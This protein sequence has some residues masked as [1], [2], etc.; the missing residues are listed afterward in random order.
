MRSGPVTGRTLGGRLPHTPDARGRES[1][2]L[3]PMAATPLTADELRKLPK[4]QGASWPRGVILRCAGCGRTG[5]P[6][7]VLGHRGRTLRTTCRRRDPEAFLT[8]EDANERS[9]D[10]EAELERELDEQ[11]AAAT[12]AY[13]GLPEPDS[14]AERTKQREQARTERAR[15]IDERA[16]TREASGRERPQK[17]PV[18]AAG[19]ETS[20]RKGAAPPTAVVHVS[21]NVP[22]EIYARF[23]ACRRDAQFGFKGE[24]GDYFCAVEPAFWIIHQWL[25]DGQPV[26]L[27]EIAGS[28]AA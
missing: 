1:V 25:A 5:L 21:F 23:D 2:F 8:L 18:G 7:S 26:P 11:A 9:R 12:E 24:I 4:T 14:D 27:T 10:M 16:G 22:A 3:A 19:N 13:L 20:E 28:L 15:A 17:A 6:A